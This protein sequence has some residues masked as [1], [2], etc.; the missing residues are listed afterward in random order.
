MNMNFKLVF[1][2]V[3]TLSIQACTTTRGT[4]YYKG[5]RISSSD[6]VEWTNDKYLINLSVGYVRLQKLTTQQIKT[7][8]V[9]EKMKRENYYT[10]TPGIMT[11][12]GA[13]FA[14]SNDSTLSAVGG[15]F[16]VEDFLIGWQK[17]YG[18]TESKT[19]G[20]I[21]GYNTR[22]DSHTENWSGS[23]KM[24]V[25]NK[26]VQTVNAVDGQAKYDVIKLVDG[27][28]PLD[29]VKGSINI[30]ASFQNVSSSISI[31]TSDIPEEFYKRKFPQYIDKYR[32]E[33]PARTSNCQSIGGSYREFFECY[34]AT[35]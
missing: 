3:A 29:L 14:A 8:S 31:K 2:I 33:N 1:A 21:N 20:T 24:Y 34:G 28:D 4:D 30:T 15:L 13:L 7:T 19:G 11:Y 12:I 6:S 5:G 27:Y 32:N 25:N 10:K 23:I 35:M 22:K 9:Y 26:Y 18:S 16:I 17:H